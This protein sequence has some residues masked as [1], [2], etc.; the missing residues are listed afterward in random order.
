[1][2]AEFSYMYNSTQNIT[3]K[4]GERSAYRT[5]TAG[6]VAEGEMGSRGEQ[7][8]TRAATGTAIA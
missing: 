1:M 7:R 6:M 5:P 8:R 4:G 3:Q 2:R